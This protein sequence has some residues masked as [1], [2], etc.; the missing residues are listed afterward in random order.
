MA[1]RLLICVSA[2]EVTVAL[3]HGGRIAECRVFPNDEQSVAAFTEFLAPLPAV[4]VFLMAD[5]VEEDYRFET[6]PHTFGSDRSEMLQ[7]KLRQHYRNAVYMSAWPQGRDSTKRRDDRYLFSAL[8][9]TELI[10]PWIRAVSARKL[11]L[12]GI[13]L[14]PLVSAALPEKLQIKNA[15]LLVVAQHNAGIRLTFFKDQHFRLSRLTRGDAARGATPAR[16]FSDE[17]SNTRLYLHALRTVTLDEHMNV[18]ILDTDNTLE[19]VATIVSQEN[20][21][22]ECAR[23]SQDDLASRLRI[24]P[25]LLEISPDVLYL[26]L[27]GQKPPPSNLAPPAATVGYRRYRARQGIYAGCTAIALA[28]IAWSSFNLWQLYEHNAAT[29]LAARQAANY[30]AQYQEITRQFPAAPTS[31]EN[32]QKL[33]ETAQKLRSSTRSPAQLMRIVATALEA[34]PNLHIR[35]FAWKYGTTDIDAGNMAAGATSQAAPSAQAP[36]SSAPGAVLPRR[37]S[38]LISGELRPFRGDYRAA[39]DAINSLAERL[40]QDPAVQTVKVAKLPLNVNP[41]LSLSGNTV[42]GA[43]QGSTAQ[44]QI[45]LSLKPQP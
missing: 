26:H 33:V 18:L 11:P 5:M 12:A 29:E 3:W 16:V 22:L 34:S 6:L 35:E 24:D 7:R 1:D 32:L 41:E 20:P 42:E 8:T 19:S 37:Q 38:G 40:A 43:E 45:L 25:A 28:G 2:P 9:N 21:S 15:N 23:L 27:L 17:I 4:P 10:D 36:A 30:Q 39:I 13:Y 14:L 31:A 44:F